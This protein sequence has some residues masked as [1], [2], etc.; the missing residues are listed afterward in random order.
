M[1]S[2]VSLDIR[3]KPL[4]EEVF[5]LL[6]LDVRMQ[7]AANQPCSTP[8]HTD[9]ET[10]WGLGTEKRFLDVTAHTHQRV[11]LT[12]RQ[13]ARGRSSEPWFEDVRQ[14]EVEIVSAED[15]VIANGDALEL[16]LAILCDVFA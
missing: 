7:R 3:Q 2:G 11:P 5:D 6:S 10:V 15:D 14:G 13:F 4:E 8:W 12:W 16:G 9:R 1:R